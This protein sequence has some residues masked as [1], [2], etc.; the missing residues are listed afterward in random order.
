MLFA[1]EKV[2]VSAQALRYERVAEVR[3]VPIQK[4]RKRWRVVVVDRYVPG[5]YQS[6]QGL[7]VH[8]TIYEA[9]RAQVQ[10]QGASDGR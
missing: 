1:G 10:P 4:R 3:R 9:L 8:P 2:I 5:A 6:A 7:I